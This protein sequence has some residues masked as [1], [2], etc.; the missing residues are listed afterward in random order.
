MAY[1]TGSAANLSDIR[2]ALIAACTANGWTWDAGNQVLYK[3]T[4]FLN[5]TYTARRMFF[6]GRTSL[7]T[8]GLIPGSTVSIGKSCVDG[9]TTWRDM[10]LSFPLTYHIFVHTDEVYLVCN[11]G[12]IYYQWATFGQSTVTGLDPAGTGMYVAASFGYNEYT[13][14]ISS[15]LYPIEYFNSDWQSAGVNTYPGSEGCII[16]APFWGPG[17]DKN[18][19]SV[20]GYGSHTNYFVHNNLDGGGW[21]TTDNNLVHGGITIGIRHLTELLNA[22]PNTFNNE[23]V[24]LPNR[25]YK[26]RASNKVSLVLDLSYSRICRIDNYDPGQIITLGADQWMV[27][28][29]LKKNTTYR[30]GYK[31]SGGAGYEGSSWIDHTGTFGWAIKYN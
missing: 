25:C 18:T 11:F 23:S 16:P 14:F 29:F 1:S 7:L 28:P 8:G 3:G 13:N 2:V 10:D 5:L 30:N 4:M 12:T 20:S 15:L 26:L 9:A 17:M 31:P 24:L 6:Q 22:L 21:S 27:F 19:N